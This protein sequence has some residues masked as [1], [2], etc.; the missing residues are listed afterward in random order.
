MVPN[1]SVA[2]NGYNNVK[3]KYTALNML[4]RKMKRDR[5]CLADGVYPISKKLLGLPI[6]SI[7]VQYRTHNLWVL[8]PEQ[9]LVTSYVIVA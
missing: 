4:K 3:T 1:F 9:P 6:R 8:G 7:E 5:K 2:L